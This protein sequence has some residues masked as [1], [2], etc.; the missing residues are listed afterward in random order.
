VFPPGVKKS[1]QDRVWP[2]SQT[3]QRQKLTVGT[4]HFRGGLTQDVV[5]NDVCIRNSPNPI[6][7]DTAY[8]AAGTLK[9]NSPPTMRDITL[10]NVRVSGGGAITFNGY[11]KDYRIAAALDG[12]QLTDAARYTY[13]LSHAD[14][15]L[16]P[17][18]TNLQ[19]PAGEDSTVQGTPS[20]AA[21]ASCAD[22]FVPFPL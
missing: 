10:R 3:K 1:I 22:K 4:G 12:V 16:G 15:T 2:A 9:G 21:P 19:L 6:T 13:V 20:S 11:A 17:A 8:S 5:Y 7:L 14:L 18:P